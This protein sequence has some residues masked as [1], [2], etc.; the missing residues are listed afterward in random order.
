MEKFP[1]SLYLAIFVSLPASI[2][3]YNVAQS[4]RWTVGAHEQLHCEF[5]FDRG[6][7]RARCHTEIVH[8]DHIEEEGAQ[9]Y[10]IAGAGPLQELWDH[11]RIKILFHSISFLIVYPWSVL[12]TLTSINVGKALG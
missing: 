10:A 12:A 1:L 7:D 6:Y 11:I 8:P 5:A 2:G 9:G 3:L 4:Q